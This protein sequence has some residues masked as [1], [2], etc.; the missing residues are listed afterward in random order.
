L[1]RRGICP[2][3]LPPAE[4]VQKVERRLDIREKKSLA[5]PDLLGEETKKM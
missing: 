5:R 2:E 3:S 4:D 1:L